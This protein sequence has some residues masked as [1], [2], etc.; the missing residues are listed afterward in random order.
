M[1]LRVSMIAGSLKPKE[2][3]CARADSGT[4]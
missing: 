3:G 1:S 4:G 2:R